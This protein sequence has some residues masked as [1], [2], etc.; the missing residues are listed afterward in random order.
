[1][2]EILIGFNCILI[3]ALLGLS[4]WILTLQNTLHTLRGQIDRLI[5]SVTALEKSSLRT[6]DAPDAVRPSVESIL[7][8]SSVLKG[9]SRPV[10]SDIPSEIVKEPTVEIKPDTILGK[11]T[12][13]AP[14]PLALPS[15]GLHWVR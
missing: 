5:Q 10:I 11:P 2:Q 1:M 4:I 13:S 12:K 6:E 15:V 3:F 9:I 7:K 14:S 8:Q